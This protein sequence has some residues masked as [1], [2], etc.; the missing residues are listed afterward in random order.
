MTGYVL[1]ACFSC[2]GCK[3]DDK[4]MEDCSFRGILLLYA[5]REKKRFVIITFYIIQ[6]IWK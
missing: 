4:H 3:L 2:Y 5:S 1:V 6:D